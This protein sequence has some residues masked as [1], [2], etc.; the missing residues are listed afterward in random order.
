MK[1]NDHE[2][3]EAKRL[4]AV[5]FKFANN[6][7][8]FEAATDLHGELMEHDLGSSMPESIHEALGVRRVE[9]RDFCSRKFGWEIC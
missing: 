8:G 7:D 9:L 3:T 4:L 1:T 6:D 5:P 2:V